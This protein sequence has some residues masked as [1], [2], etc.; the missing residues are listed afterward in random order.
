VFLQVFGILCVDVLICLLWSAIARPRMVMEE[1][2][3]GNVYAVIANPVCSATIRQ[4]FEI[5]MVIWKALLLAFGVGKAIQTWDV[6]EE[7]SEAKYFAVAIYNIAVVGSFTY[8]LS[9]FGTGTGSVETFVVLRCVGIFV[10]STMSTIV[11]MVPKLLVIQLN[12]T[13]LLLGGK[14]S[15]ED[16]EYTEPDMSTTPGGMNGVNTAAQMYVDTGNGASNRDWGHQDGGLVQ[17]VVPQH[18]LGSTGQTG[19]I[20]HLG[21][22]S[23]SLRLM[24]NRMQVAVAADDQRE[25]PL[26]A[27]V[28]LG[29]G[30]LPRLD[31]MALQGP[32]VHALVP[33]LTLPTVKGGSGGSHG[34]GGSFTGSG[35]ANAKGLV[36]G[37]QG[38]FGR[39]KKDEEDEDA[40]L[41][42]RDRPD[43]PLP[44]RLERPEKAD[45]VPEKPERQERGERAE[46]LERIKGLDEP[47]PPGAGGGYAAEGK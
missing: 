46:R 41:R 13:E 6:P 35:M 8:F 15:L 30:G 37:V 44:D 4:P 16:G 5:A 18:P 45:R 19:L 22:T 17:L 25:S 36:H 24:G 26:M 29:P 12:W 21:S 7:I 34:S 20:G 3:Y 14:S 28:P 23:G 11:I 32:S 2:S 9:V 33:G 40:K 42:N 27:T 31:Q 10:A 1:V 39:S 38:L 43:R 47:E